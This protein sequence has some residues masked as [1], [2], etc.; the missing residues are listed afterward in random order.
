MSARGIFRTVAPVIAPVIALVTAITVSLLPGAAAA[1]DVQEVTS[2]G[3][4][5][6]YLSEDHTNPIIGLSLNFKGG[7]AL[8]PREKAGLSNM[9]VALLDEGS[10]PRDSLAFQTA[11]EDLSIRW[12]FSA[13]Q[14]GILGMVTTTTEN[15]ATAFELLHD[16]LT[17]PHFENEAV[18]RIRRQILVGLQSNLENPSR[19]AG[20]ALVAALF[21]GHPYGVDDDGTLDTVAAISVDDLKAWAKSR[22]ARDRLIISASGDITP[23]QLGAAMDRIFGDLPATTGLDWRLPEAEIPT[24]GQEIRIDKPIPQTVIYIGQEG[25]KRDDP[26]WYAEQIVD[27]VFGG[28]SFESRLV[29]EI[30]EKRGLAYS[31]F[32]SVAPLDAGSYVI[33]GAG[34]RSEAAEQSLAV[35]REEWKKLYDKGLTKQEL[36]EAKQYLTGSWPLRFT[37]T[38]SIAN[39]LIA[40]Q[41]DNLGLNYLDHRNDLIEKVT[42]DDVNRVAR[43]IYN[44]D[45]LQIVVVGPA[46]DGAATGGG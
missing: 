46:P 39:T 1:I 3:G 36:D 18:E 9:A 29:D 44:P 30:R 2:P 8:D 33:A 25:I 22:F 31:A 34:T 26:D 5:K 41:R 15:S 17:S 43:R 28:G 14:D 12:R 20:A 37:S 45:T 11:L 32:S 13:D 7:A 35:F 21:P 10:G 42:L 16:G 19:I 38:Q 24:K 27:Y 4:L 6:A 40:V 23:A